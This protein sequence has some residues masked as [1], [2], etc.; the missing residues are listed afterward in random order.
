MHEW[1]EN[2]GFWR[3][4]YPYMFD[5]QGF[6]AADEQVRK[7]IKLTGIGAARCLI[8]AAVP[9]GILWRWPSAVFG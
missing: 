4:M 7:I 8:C 2:E 3:E 9:D 6:A 5:E 1:F